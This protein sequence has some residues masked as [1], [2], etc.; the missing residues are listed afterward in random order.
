MEEIETHDATK[1]RMKNIVLVEGAARYIDLPE[2]WGKLDR[3]G[4]SITFRPESAGKIKRTDFGG[5][6]FATVYHAKSYNEVESVSAAEENRILSL[7]FR[8]LTL[9][10]K[11][12]NWSEWRAHKQA[13]KEGAIN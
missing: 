7:G 8:K 4:D 10:E 6:K 2:N 1:N 9:D 11:E 12:T 13:Q 5:I 3:R